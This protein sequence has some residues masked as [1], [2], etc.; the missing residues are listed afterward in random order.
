MTWTIN[1]ACHEETFGFGTLLCH[2]KSLI[3]I[4][5][6]AAAEFPYVSI[7]A[8]QQY[9]DRPFSQKFLMGVFA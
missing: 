1:P 2:I 5:V 6:R 9:F 7:I 4:K 3:L 8:F